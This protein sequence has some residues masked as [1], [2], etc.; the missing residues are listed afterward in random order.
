MRPARLAAGWWF[1]AGLALLAAGCATQQQEAFMRG[2]GGVDGLV[3]SVTQ[4]AG[5]VSEPE[6][7]AMG[8]GV[9]E[10]LLG[11]R[12]LVDDGELQRYVN[13]VGTWVASQSERPDLP[14]RFGVNDSDHVNAFAAPGGVVI[15]TRG[16][17]NALNSEAELAGV[18]GHEIAHVTR[19]HHLQALRKSA[20][21]NLLGA[22][23]AAGAAGTASRE[24]VSALVGPT[25]ELYARGLDKSDE[26]EA[27]RMGVVLA[28]RAG[29]DPFGLPEAL[30]TLARIKADDPYLAL[31]FKTHPNPGERL[32]RLAV[33]MGPGFDALPDARQNADRF[34]NATRRLKPLPR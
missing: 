10:T 18:L 25:Q 6:E 33:A 2:V 27:D 9:A 4:L 1:A 5:G 17:I 22:T 14:W 8:R 32:D 3:K 21:M 15:V 19:R 12:P 11:A 23:A 13:A 30:Q 16:M 29:Y 31:L 7:V 34:L 26:F 28:A 24:L 20:A